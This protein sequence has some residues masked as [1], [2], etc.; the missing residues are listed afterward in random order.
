MKIARTRIANAIAS[1]TLKNGTSKEYAK[2]I[3]AY[4]L[5]DHRVHELDSLTRDVRAAWAEDGYIEA[6]ASSAH[7][8]TAHIKNDI[9][10]EVKKIYPSAKKI[11]ITEVHDAAVIGGVRLSLPNQQ[12][13][14]SVENKLN[15]LKRLT[16]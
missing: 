3:A 4:L 6:V 9:I 10:S 5:S 13:D 15:Q 2:E 12:L 1:R 16:V 11:I 8:L 14:L 7:P